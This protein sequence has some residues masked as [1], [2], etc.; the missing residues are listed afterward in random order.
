MGGAGREDEMI[1]LKIKNKV[2][3]SKTYIFDSAASHHVEKESD[4]PQRKRGNI[5]VR[6]VTGEQENVPVIEHGLLQ[7]CLLMPSSP[8]N[9]VSMRR[10]RKKGFVVK[11]DHERDEFR[12]KKSGI[13]S[14][15]FSPRGDDG[16]YACDMV[17]SNGIWTNLDDSTG[18]GEGVR[19]DGSVLLLD[20]GVEFSE[21]EK[22]RAARVIEIHR[23]LAHPADSVL[24]KLLE[25]G[26]YTGLTSKDLYNARALFGK[27]QACLR[28]KMTR[29]RRGGGVARK[30]RISSSSTPR[31]GE[32]L[33]IDIFFIKSKEYLLSRDSASGY[34]SCAALKS[35]GKEH[36][37]DALRSIVADF[38]A[39]GHRVR[40]I[41]SDR[42]RAIVVAQNEI[43]DWGIFLELAGAEDHVSR[44]ERAIRTLK[45]KVRAVLLDLPFRLP[46]SCLD[47][48]I[49][50][51]SRTCNLVPNSKTGVLSPFF[52][53]TNQSPKLL[54]TSISFGD[55][56]VARVPYVQKEG[57]LAERGEFAIYLGQES[58]LSRVAVVFRIE[59]GEITHISKVE[60][61][62]FDL[63]PHDK[64]STLMRTLSTYQY[65]SAEDVGDAVQA[66][67]PQNIQRFPQFLTEIPAIPQVSEPILP[68]NEEPSTPIL[69][70]E[71]EGIIYSEEKQDGDLGD[72]EEKQEYL[73]KLVPAGPV[74]TPVAEMHQADHSSPV[75][76]RT[77]SKHTIAAILE[78]GNG[79]KSSEKGE[80]SA[81]SSD[82]SIIP[83]RNSDIIAPT[84]HNNHVV[85]RYTDFANM[86]SAGAIAKRETE[87]ILRF[88]DENNQL[89]ADYIYQNS[90]KAHN[91]YKGATEIHNCEVANAGAFLK[92]VV[93][94]DSM[95]NLTKAT[96]LLS[97]SKAKQHFGDQRVIAALGKEVT[98]LLHTGTFVP[99]PRSEALRFMV[100]PTSVVFSEKA[101]G[102]LK[103]RIVGNGNLQDRSIYKQNEISSPTMRHET[104][105]ILLSISAE[106]G[107]RISCFDVAGAYLKASLPTK[108]KIYVRFGKD[109]SEILTKIDDRAE[110]D[111][112]G[113]AYGK[114]EKGL[115]GLLEA[116]R[117]WNETLSRALVDA[118]YTRSFQD[119]CLF[120]RWDNG[121]I[122]LIGVH[123][124]DLLMSTWSE[125][126]ALR[127]RRAL[128]A[129]FGTMKAQM[130]DKLSY[131]GLTITTNQ[132]KREVVL[133]QEKQIEELAGLILEGLE[134]LGAARRT[135][136]ALNLFQ[137]LD[138]DEP[139]TDPAKFR[140]G[141][142]KAVWICSQSRPDIK[143]VCSFLSSRLSQ[144]TKQDEKKLRHMVEY[145]LSTKHMGLRFSASNGRARGNS[146]GAARDRVAA[147]AGGGFASEGNGLVLSAQADASCHSHSDFSGQTGGILFL[148][149]NCIGAISKRQKMVV[150]SACEAE[151]FALEMVVA[152]VQWARY[153]LEEM[154]FKQPATTV[155]QDN[156][157]T[158]QIV[159]SGLVSSKT[160]HINWRHMRA[161]KLIKAGEITL[162]ELRSEDMTADM[163]T[164][165]LPGD[166]FELH[167]EKL[168]NRR[169]CCG[170]VVSEAGGES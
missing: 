61:V 140:T 164:K 5:S 89:S 12:V 52:L 116:G 1:E 149:S 148:G 21:E 98:Q 144:P 117:L 44:A 155:Y 17:Y 105:M 130:G 71:S 118:G 133:T 141:V 42:E 67:Q 162:S 40:L 128:E 113:Y 165:A 123:V 135:P 37:V 68:P 15:S 108:T 66:R 51:T 119:P 3:P 109:T 4:Y 35:R 22:E 93:E 19:E 107:N 36:V 159:E 131:L 146:S 70:G 99:R 2:I 111:Q 102:E 30:S 150:R 145:L 95:E 137:T 157:A 46:T 60:R 82:I 153:L 81:I 112:Q 86:P 41:K 49:Q 169:V 76:S 24:I 34:I 9:I 127:V 63:L 122:S 16:M 23:Q 47:R 124:D 10:M 6:G 91:G 53:V 161:H 14:L 50:H 132:R 31:I 114:L 74:T 87:R 20:S 147:G 59:K 156:Q 88:F 160:K 94:C 72:A 39:H 79:T 100:I 29:G 84:V 56:V 166:A 64:R 33:S 110:V 73:K 45:G 38:R 58:Y 158:M 18:G 55:L 26:A 54:G 90:Q 80:N 8:Y 13:C 142:A 43:A 120:Y 11:Y 154:G 32:I 103:A 101:T 138:K 104:L 77:R 83:E 115:Y 65:V 27:C 152:E 170:E 62:F 7:E 121:K 134:N 125:Q 96:I 163:L 139:A 151:I 92:G 28:A 78:D 97:I 106:L 167:R 25:D 168:M 75:S 129:E 126:E 69:K 136:H 85:G 57:S 48:L 143:V